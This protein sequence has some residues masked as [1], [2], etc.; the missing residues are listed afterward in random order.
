MKLSRRGLLQGCIASSVVWPL[1]VYGTAATD[2]RF[3]LLILRGAVDG[4]AMIPPIG[5]KNYGDGRSSLVDQDTISLNGDF[6]M[7]PALRPMLPLWKNKQ[8]QIIHATGLMEATRS[9]FASQD[10]LE[11]GVPNRYQGWL[12]LGLQRAFPG[13]KAVA[14]GQSVPLVLRGA[15]GAFSLSPKRRKQTSDTFIDLVNGMYTN[16]SILKEALQQSIQ[17]KMMSATASNE[18]DKHSVAGISKLLTDPDGPRV[19]VLEIGGWDTHSNQNNRLNRKLT[20]LGKIISSLQQQLQAVWKQTTILAVTEFGRTVRENGTKGT[21]HGSGSAALL[22]GGSVSGGEVVG[23]W[24]GLRK[25]DLY[26]SRDLR[27]TTDIRTI[28]KQQLRRLYGLN[29][30]DLQVLF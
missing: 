9:H 19:A 11:S 2:Q 3:I 18:T 13:A 15:E 30:Q 1:S 21:D 6:G 5:D 4:L 22:L 10:L 28:F 17:T 12:G 16:D 24:P 23:D 25:Q 14:V 7:H 20:Q 8:L 29:K 26:E 27:I